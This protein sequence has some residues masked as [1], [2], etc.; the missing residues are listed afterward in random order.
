MSQR[1]VNENDKQNDE[2]EHI[3]PTAELMRLMDSLEAHIETAL[4]NHF[5]PPPEEAAEAQPQQSSS[6]SLG[7]FLK[8]RVVRTPSS[9]DIS[10]IEDAIGATPRLG[11]KK[12]KSQAEFIAFPDEA[13]AIEN[14][15]RI[16]EL[17]VIG[18]NY[19]TNLQKEQSAYE[20]RRK[21][22][23]KSARDGISTSLRK[24]SEEEKPKQNME[25]SQLFDIFLERNGMA[26]LVEMLIGDRLQPPEGT[27]GKEGVTYL[28]A[29]NVAV[30]VL[31][32]ICILIQNVSRATSLYALLSNNHVNQLIRMKL[33][34]YE[35]A[36]R[37]RIGAKTVYGT[38]AFTELTT[39]FVTFL[40]SLAMRM[41]AETLQFFLIFPPGGGAMEFP[42]YE[43]S[44]KLCSSQNDSFV[45]TTALNICLN[46]LRLS[47]VNNVDPLLGGGAL[48][49]QERVF[50][51]EYACV[52][53]TVE[54]LIAP[55]FSKLA[56]HW[57]ALDESIRA[58]DENRHM[59]AT[60]GRNE[61]V[62]MEK[63][64]IRRERLIR[65]FQEA[66]GNLQDE[67]YLLDDI[68]KVR[69]RRV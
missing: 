2:K 41:N 39:H 35:A 47:A 26:L 12:P 40:K 58:M 15:R 1:V 37:H 17:C 9:E 49:F 16:A 34:L 54:Q 28:P 43:C 27:Q 48:E 42:L 11:R 63:E 22:E 21:D 65:T 38:P 25:K 67:L 19:V 69:I 51:A 29:I 60:T 59:S 14:I 7:R 56:A 31:Q 4:Q 13:P 50:I 30:Q 68:F 53:S 44:L 66:V 46:T 3:T 23:W 61:R 8:R 18:E 52:P 33:K 62:V 57:S 55:V 36:E 45:R 5:K 24:M 32:S 6:L 64:K 10:S 20:Q